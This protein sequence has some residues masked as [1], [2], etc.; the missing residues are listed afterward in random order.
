MAGEDNPY[1]IAPLKAEF[2]DAQTEQAFRSYVEARTA[3]HLKTTIIVWALLTLLFG[4]LDYQDLGMSPG[5]YLLMTMRVGAA[6]ML[7]VLYVLVSGRPNLATAGWPVTLVAILGFPLM[8]VIFFVRPDTAAWNV[9]VISIMLISIYVFLPNR[10]M[11]NTLVAAYGLIGTLTTLTLRGSDAATLIALAIVMLLPVVTGFVAA[12]RLQVVQRQ[13]FALLQRVTLA[14]QD[15]KQEI[16]RR[17]EL[18]GELQRQATTDPLTGLSNRRQYEMLFK[19]E[20]ERCARQGGAMVVGIAD[21]D[22]FKQI[23]DTHGH[24]L[25]DQALKHVAQIFL[26]SLRQSDVVGRFGGEEFILLLPDTQITQAQ[27]VV[28]RLR[29]QLANT[30]LVAGSLKIPVTAT[31]AITQVR[32]D[33]DSIEDIIRRADKSLYQGKKAGRNR[34]V[35]AA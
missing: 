17:K 27:A 11:L 25:G 16:E 34:V 10:L 33:D 19:R 7:A 15:L 23:N 9:G 21:L 26:D 35:V 32:V 28:E 12:R 31:F 18:E 3:R 8:F 24:D 1:A 13:E 2:R 14:N 29:E 4:L 22:H 30:P 5:F 20:R 6:A